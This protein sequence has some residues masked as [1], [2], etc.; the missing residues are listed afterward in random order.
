[1]SIKIMSAVFESEV[2]GPTERLIMLALADHADD[3]GRCY[4]SISRLCQRT[5]LGERAIQNNIKALVS[6]G[7]VTIVPNA[8]Q[9]LA[10][11]Y[12]VTATPAPDAPPHEMRPRT[13]CAS[14]PASRSKTPAPDAPKPSGTII[15]PSS[16][17]R[18]AQP[19]DILAEVVSADAAASFASFRRQTKKPLTATAARRLRG[20]L[21]EIKAQGGDPDDALGMAEER[22]WQS[23]RPEWY[24]KETAR[25][26]SPQ[27][28]R[29]SAASD[30]L[31]YQLDVAAR[32]RRPSSADCF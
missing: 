20:A 12:F 2:L 6:K 28:N 31:R 16:S 18:G 23:I 32:M 7:Y 9:G 26:Q 10:N 13:K 5:G 22:G 1:M 27:H 15:E 8:G 11:L 4:P 21:L 3:T 14:T 30:A 29:Q 19:I 24:F 17:K 25:V